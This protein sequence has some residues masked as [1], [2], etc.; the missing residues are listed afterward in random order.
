MWLVI[1]CDIQPMVEGGDSTTP[2]LLEAFP[3][4]ISKLC[5]VGGDYR[6]AIHGNIEFAGTAS[7]ADSVSVRVSH[8]KRLCFLGDLRT[9]GDSAALGAESVRGLEGIAV[10]G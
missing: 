4:D 7:A 1:V 6:L 9:L 10:P 8:F 5:T 2:D 3:N